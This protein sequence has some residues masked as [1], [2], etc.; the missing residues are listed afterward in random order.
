ME[1]SPTTA[2]VGEDL[3]TRNWWHVEA[4]NLDGDSGVTVVTFT[5]A[6]ARELAF[7]WAREKFDHVEAGH[8]R[9]NLR[10]VE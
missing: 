1:K 4:H 7:E 5:G 10:V 9:P 6:M 3:R 2:Y 8:A